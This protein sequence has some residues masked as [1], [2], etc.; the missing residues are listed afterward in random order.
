M[1]K[2][3]DYGAVYIIFG[4]IFFYV[5]LMALAAFAD[6]GMKSN[7]IDKT[8]PVI[9]RGIMLDYEIMKIRMKH[10]ELIKKDTFLMP[11]SVK[12]KIQFEVDSYRHWLIRGRHLRQRRNI[13]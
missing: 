2:K 4:I 12:R 9:D 10:V 5:L 3:K 6:R 11:D 8:R 7:E 13:R 1:R